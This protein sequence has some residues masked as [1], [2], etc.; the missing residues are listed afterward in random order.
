MSCKIGI[1]ARPEERRAHVEM[2]YRTAKDWQILGSYGRRADATAAQRR[3]AG[4]MGC[5]M[6]KDDDAPDDDS[7]RQWHVYRFSHGKQPKLSEY[8]GLKSLGI[9][10]D[11]RE[12]A[13]EKPERDK[14]DG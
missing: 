13:E 7:G 9:E 2:I 14:P 4:Q 8:G 11:Q 1:T 5:Q 10:R 6:I 3:F 12:E